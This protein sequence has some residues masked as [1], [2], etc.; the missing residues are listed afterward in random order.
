MEA[1]SHVT[2][3][4]D[5]HSA[6][7]IKLNCICKVI[8]IRV[9]YKVVN[10]LTA[11][12]P[13]ID[14]T[15]ILISEI[16][17]DIEGETHSA[18]FECF[19]DLIENQDPGDQHKESSST[20]DEGMP[21]NADSASLPSSLPP[22]L[23]PSPDKIQSM[24]HSDVMPL[25]PQENIQPSDPNIEHNDVAKTDPTFFSRELQALV[26]TIQDSNKSKP[27]M[28]DSQPELSDFLKKHFLQAGN[29]ADPAKKF[30]TFKSPKQI[31]CK[32][33]LMVFNTKQEL[34]NHK[35]IVHNVPF[36]TYE[37][38]ICSRPFG[39]NSHLQRHINSVH[40]KVKQH[41][42]LYCSKSFS[43]YDKLKAHS[44]R[45][46][47]VLVESI[48]FC[49]KCNTY[50]SSYP[51]F[52]KHTC[53]AGVKSSELYDKIEQ[54]CSSK[55][56]GEASEENRPGPS[57]EDQNNSS[58][59][60]QSFQS[61]SEASNSTTPTTE[62]SPALPGLSLMQPSPSLLPSVTPL[63]P[64]PAPV[65]FP[66]PLPAYNPLLQNEMNWSVQT[67]E[68]IPQTESFTQFT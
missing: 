40:S 14:L 7:V 9:L 21:L 20:T 18:V 39:N 46:H 56:E 2:I 43:R 63:N 34:L 27:E 37:C 25:S 8:S 16:Y 23:P 36:K 13:V 22:S 55:K 44:K 68:Y 67:E 24:S 32:T 26:E 41:K 66:T 30:P 12:G 38:H 49:D 4:V 64:Y 61:D 47:N 31:A 10:K 62:F 57:Q 35:L 65:Q 51:Q 52:N 42:C 6:K 15:D 54:L 58:L 29:N 59:T 1:M 11:S 60:L 5:R 33:C 50:F 19:D 53:N 45:L 28:I 3:N 48:I 17:S